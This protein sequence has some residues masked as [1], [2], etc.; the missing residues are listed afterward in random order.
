MNIHTLPRRSPTSLEAIAASEQRMTSIL[1]RLTLN[2]PEDQGHN[3]PSPKSDSF[4][5]NAGLNDGDDS[6][7]SS[8]SETDEDGH[9]RPAFRKSRVI[10]SHCSDSGLGSSVSSVAESA[11]GDEDKGKTD[12]GAIQFSG[13]LSNTLSA[14]NEDAQLEESAIKTHPTFELT[15]PERR[16]LHLGACKQI[17]RY[18]L[19]PLLKDPKFKPFHALVESVPKRIVKKQ[20]VCL[21]DLEKT[22]LWLK[23]VSCQQ[24][25]S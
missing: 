16:Q 9:D 15:S 19:A 24:F 3:L 12:L 6:R 22:L 21:R 5:P 7:N 2:S 25:H 11:F 18:I 1:E 17:E 10:H 14:V 23:P 4:S 13:P 8:S 20:I